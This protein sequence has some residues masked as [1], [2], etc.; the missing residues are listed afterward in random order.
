MKSNEQNSDNPQTPDFIS[1]TF[2]RKFDRRRSVV[3]M[4]DQSSQRYQQKMESVGYDKEF[5]ETIYGFEGEYPAM[6]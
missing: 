1:K 2:S 5:Y 3:V 6:A 4:D